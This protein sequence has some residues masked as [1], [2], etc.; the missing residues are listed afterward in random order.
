[1]IHSNKHFIYF[2]WAMIH[3]NNHFIYF[4]WTVAF[5]IKHGGLQADLNGGSGGVAEPPVIFYFICSMFETK[6]DRIPYCK[7]SQ[8][9]TLTTN[10]ALA[11]KS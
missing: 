5:L 1:M 7:A 3:S 10:L 2:K 6:S 11:V 4:K 9:S 8:Q